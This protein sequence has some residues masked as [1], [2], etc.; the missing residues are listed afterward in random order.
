MNHEY[1]GVWRPCGVCGQA[2]PA[3]RLEVLPNTR[4]CVSCQSKLELAAQSIG[5]FNVDDVRQGEWSFLETK[6][7]RDQLPAGIT[8]EPSLYETISSLKETEVIGGLNEE[9][10][11]ACLRH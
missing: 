8:I 3:K 2:I 11:K 6:E 7:Y 1:V 10:C 5:N 9:N 4:T